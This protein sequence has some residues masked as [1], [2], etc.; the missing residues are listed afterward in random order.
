MASLKCRSEQTQRIG[1]EDRVG[2]ER[3]DDVGIRAFADARF[4]AD[5]LPP[6][7]LLITRTRGSSSKVRRTTSA[8]PSV[9]PSSTTRILKSSMSEASIARTELQMTFSSL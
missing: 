1:R 7:F 4:R 3:D 8:V 2:I 9:E 6:L 5:H